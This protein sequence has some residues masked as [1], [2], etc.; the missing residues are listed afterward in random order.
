MGKVAPSVSLLNKEMKVEYCFIKSAA[1]YVT[2][3]LFYLL[4]QFTLPQFMHFFYFY[5]LFEVDLASFPSWINEHYLSFTR[6]VIV[7]EYQNQREPTIVLPFPFQMILDLSFIVRKKCFHLLLETYHF[8]FP[9][10][11]FSLA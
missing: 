10:N 4:F 9:W 5:F 11:K 3:K 1:S 8:F 6:Y 7:Q 2:Y